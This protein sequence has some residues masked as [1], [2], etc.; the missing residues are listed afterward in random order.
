LQRLQVNGLNRFGLLVM[1]LFLTGCSGDN[2]WTN[3]GTVFK[4][5][6]TNSSQATIDTSNFKNGRLTISGSCGDE[7]DIIMVL[8]ATKGDN[9]IIGSPRC[10]HGRYNLITSTFGRPPCEVIVEYSGDKSVRAKVNGADMYCP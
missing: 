2:Q 3:L 10:S 7:G 1:V 9:R 8:P 5:T 4:S 6:S